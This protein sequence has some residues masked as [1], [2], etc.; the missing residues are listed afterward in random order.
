MAAA[1]SPTS[2]PNDRASG[3]SPPANP[4]PTA[5]NFHPPSRRYNSPKTIAAS[6]AATSGG[7]KR[8]APSATPIAASVSIASVWPRACASW[9]VTQNTTRSIAAGS[10]AGSIAN[11]PRGPR[12]AAWRIAPAAPSGWL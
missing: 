3:A 12:S 8:S 11:P 10:R 6:G 2:I 4:C 9:T 1:S 7:A 5:R